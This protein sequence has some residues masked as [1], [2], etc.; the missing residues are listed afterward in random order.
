MYIPKGHNHDDWVAKRTKHQADRNANKKQGKGAAS[1][2]PLNTLTKRKSVS[3]LALSKSLK[4]VLLRK[5]QL[6][7]RE[8]QEIV[9]SAMADAA[10]EDSDM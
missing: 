5:F 4:F 10:N 1:V 2:Y 8:T 9:D 6:S 7:D 3:K